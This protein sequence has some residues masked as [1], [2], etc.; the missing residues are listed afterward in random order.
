MNVRDK[1]RSWLFPIH[2]FPALSRQAINNKHDIDIYAEDLKDDCVM[3]N[4]FDSS[5]ETE[6]QRWIKPDKAIACLRASLSLAARAIYKYSLGL[7][8]ED[9]KKPHL[10]I[11]MR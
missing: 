3:Q 7:S 6:A 9:Q 2:R 5:K 4:W 8:D 1:E 11:D 10:V